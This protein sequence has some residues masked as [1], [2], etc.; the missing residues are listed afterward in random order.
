MKTPAQKIL[1]YPLNLQRLLTE[2]VADPDETE[3][4]T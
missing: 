3:G 1:T 2:R 4:Q